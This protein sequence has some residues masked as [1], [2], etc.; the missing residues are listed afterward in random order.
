MKKTA[1]IGAALGLALSFGAAS[2]ASATVYTFTQSESFGAGSFGQ[3][4]V[5]QDA[6]NANALDFLVQINQGELFHA[7]TDGNHHA[8]TFDLVGNPDITISGLP[9]GFTLNGD[10]SNGSNKASAFGNFDYVI[11]LPGNGTPYAPLSFSFVATNNDAIPAP[12]VLDYNTVGGNKI[13][14][15]TDVSTSGATGNVAAT[16]TGGS[17]LKAGVPEPASW[18]MMLLGFGGVGAM[19]RRRRS[20]ALALA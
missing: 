4:T 16:Y 8:L 5:T 6:T 1:L 10:Q 19:L 20:Q 11:N 14:F 3:V 15:T 12:L 9:T 13:Y 7:A 2:M 17:L 18:A